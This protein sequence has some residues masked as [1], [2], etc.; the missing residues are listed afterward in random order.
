[1]L[2]S[3]A[4]LRNFVTVA[5]ERQFRRAS[6]K[7]GLSQPTLS[8]Q[9][10][11]IEMALGVSLINRTTR[12]MRLTVEG[13]RFFHRARQILNDIEAAVF[14]AQQGSALQHGRLLIASTPSIAANLLP[15]TLASFGERFPDINVDM[16]E[17]TISGVEAKVR[18]G[19]ADF[20]IGPRTREQPELCFS[21]LFK[22]RFLAVIPEAHELAGAKVVSASQL[23]R[24]PLLTTSHG[25]GIR[26]A[27][28][29]FTQLH[30]LKLNV[31]HNI[32]RH[33]TVI[34]MVEAGLGIGLMPELSLRQ[35]SRR[36]IPVALSDPLS[37]DIGILER[38]GGSSSS[39]AAQFIEI[40]KANPV[41][42]LLKK[43]LQ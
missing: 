34:A 30:K 32:T 15:A 36:V 25:T 20:G 14:E 12:S 2:V 6:I 37:R 4:K 26:G 9:I 40:F 23:A 31:G 33:E 39:A 22:E 28:D 17:D 38:K 27:V 41:L 1:M 18:D 24:Y 19:P 8:A 21:L 5:E 11:D 43:E 10:R 7:L 35:Q 42:H 3:F 29:R 16:Y 13:E